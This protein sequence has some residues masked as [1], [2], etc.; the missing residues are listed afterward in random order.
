MIVQL[1]LL[2]V[3]LPLAD[4]LLLLI[5]ARFTGLW[6][7]LGLV[8]ASAFCGVLLAKRQWRQIGQRAQQQLAQNQIPSDLA[9]EAV[10]VVLTAGLLI[11]PGVITDLI[12]LSL[13]WPRCR[14]WYRERLLNW[15]RSAFRISIFTPSNR[16]WQ[17]PAGQEV[18]DAEF[19]SH[20]PATKSE[21]P[22]L[23]EDS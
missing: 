23:E 3:L 22:R 6:P 13:L 10:L 20:P 9:S 16:T 7:A 8:I 2:I 15:L 5:I 19:R 18:Y 4:L 11:T 12:G 17:A 14:R 1:L 21:P